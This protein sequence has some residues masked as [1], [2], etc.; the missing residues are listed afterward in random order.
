[1]KGESIRLVKFGAWWNAFRRDER[2]FGTLEVLLILAVIVLIAVV[3]RKWIIA[4]VNDLFASTNQ[5]IQD[6]LENTGSLNHP[7]I[8]EP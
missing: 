5:Q 7:E 3:F 2:G 1:M 4:W 8:L 6:Q